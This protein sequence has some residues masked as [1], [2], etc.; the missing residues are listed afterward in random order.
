MPSSGR[1]APLEKPCLRMLIDDFFDLVLSTRSASISSSF[2]DSES[3]ASIPVSSRQQ[4]D[5]SLPE[6]SSTL[7]LPTPGPRLS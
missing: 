1:G 5:H 7:L 6:K 4:A 2:D 3:A